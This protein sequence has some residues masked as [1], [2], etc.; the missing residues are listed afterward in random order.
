M[1]AAGWGG[2]QNGQI[3]L[4]AMRVTEEGQY[5]HPNAHRAWG[6]LVRACAADTRVWM[7][8]NEG[9][10]DLAKQ[11]YYWDLY[12]SGQGNIAAPPGYSNHGRGI[13][14]DIA[15]YES[16]FGWLIA[17]A[18]KFQWSWAT[19]QASGERW[20]WEFTGSLIVTDMSGDTGKPI[21]EGVPE[22][23][24]KFL[25]KGSTSNPVYVIDLGTQTRTY[26]GVS[27]IL[28]SYKAAGYK[29]GVID[30]KIFDAIPKQPGTR[31]HDGS[32]VPAPKP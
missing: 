13:A 15:G 23:A 4:S 32:I 26:L 9:Y 27:G 17:N 10:R 6:D 28:D 3:P 2:F 12:Q 11:Q 31:D 24:D 7:S 19:G 8:C 5:L 1:A 22:M 18:Q 25:A 29:L 16:V 21:E 14:V 20:H 30:Q